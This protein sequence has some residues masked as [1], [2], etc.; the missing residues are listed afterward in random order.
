MR[1]VQKY[2]I[3]C[4]KQKTI[5]LSTIKSPAN[6][7]K[8]QLMEVKINILLKTGYFITCI[9]LIVVFLTSLTMQ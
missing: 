5:I 1:F 6:N 7:S 9:N 4:Y 2:Y 3:W 8:S